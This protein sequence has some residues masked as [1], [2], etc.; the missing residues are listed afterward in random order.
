VIV[1]AALPVSQRDNSPFTVD[2]LLPPPDAFIGGENFTVA[3]K[4]QLSDPGGAPTNRGGVLAHVGDPVE[5]RHCRKR[6]CRHRRRRLIPMNRRAMVDTPMSNQVH[7][8]ANEL[9]RRCSIWRTVLL[10]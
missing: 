9:P 6:C 1:T 10:R 2:G 3:D 8:E 7:F 4:T 5:Y